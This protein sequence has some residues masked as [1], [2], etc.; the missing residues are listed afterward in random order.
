M[1][2]YRELNRMTRAE[3]GENTGGHPAQHLSNMARCNRAI[4]LVTAKKMSAVF[5]VFVEHFV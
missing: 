4:S 1:K 5:K 3:L 2:L